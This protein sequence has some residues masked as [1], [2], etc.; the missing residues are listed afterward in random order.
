ML[1]VAASAGHVDIVR[2]L[3]ER[4][5]DL[6]IKDKVMMFPRPLEIGVNTWLETLEPYV[7]SCRLEIDVLFLASLSQFCRD[8]MS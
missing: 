7:R 3:Y 4:G 1:H 8:T 2:F 5:I 6:N